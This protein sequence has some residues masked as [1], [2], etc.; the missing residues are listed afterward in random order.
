MVDGAVFFIASIF[1]LPILVG[2]GLSFVDAGMRKKLLL[3]LAV[4]L[5][6]SVFWLYRFGEVE[7][8]TPLSFMGEEISFS[9]S[10][11]SLLIFFVSLLSLIGMILLPGDAKHQISGINALLLGVSI[12]FGFI[13]FISGQFMIR[14]IALDIVGLIAALMVLKSLKNQVIFRSFTLIFAIL[15]FGDLSLLASIL[16]LQSH[17]GT[18]NITDMINIAITLPQNVRLWMFAGFF[19]AVLVKTAVWP[20]ILWMRHAHKGSNDATFWVSGMLMPSLGYYLLYRVQPLI[21]SSGQI[22]TLVGLISGGLILMTILLDFLDHHSFDHFSLMSA[23][24]SSFLFAASAFGP[25]DHL[26]YLIAALL[27]YRFILYLHGKLSSSGM[28]KFTTL[29]LFIINAAFVVVGSDQ[30]PLAFIFGWAAFS[31]LV[32]VWGFL[33]DQRLRLGDVRARGAMTYLEDKS[34]DW[35]EKGTV[36]INKNL[37]IAIFTNGIYTLG[38]AFKDSANWINEKIE[39]GI[40]TNGFYRLSDVLEGSAGWLS[41]KVEQG[42]ERFWS[43]IG[44]TLMKISEGTFVKFEVEPSQKSEVLLDNAL[45]SLDKY[46][47]NVLR[48]NLRLDLVWIP[49]FLLIIFV[50]I[51]FV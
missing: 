3:I 1:S 29:P 13:A 10:N 40:F 8:I 34:L 28:N 32:V 21:D 24:S 27:L 19:L 42:M 6:F 43:W 35:I 4:S 50:L 11:A 16:L 30:L 51:L 20:F 41:D 14:Y 49:L 33:R 9:I 25:K 38:Q 36:W 37:E 5:L 48:K 2:I 31:L 7:I 39:I 26:K 47:Q 18:L 22:K 17:A 12:S 23:F 15:R 46:E 45:N 44:N